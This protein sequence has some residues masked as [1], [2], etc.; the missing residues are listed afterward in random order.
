[1]QIAYDN[2]RLAKL[3]GIDDAQL[4]GDTLEALYK[5]GI[6]I[7]QD[8]GGIYLARV[9]D[10]TTVVSKSAAE[11]KSY[12]DKSK[13]AQKNSSTDRCHDTSATNVMTNVE[14]LSH[15]TT[16]NNLQSTNTITTTNT[17]RETDP[18]VEFSLSHIGE[19]E[20]LKD[21]ICDDIEFASSLDNSTLRIINNAYMQS[22]FLRVNYKHWSKVKINKDKIMT[23][24]YQQHK[25]P[26]K[27]NTTQAIQNSTP[28]R[29]MSH[30]EVNDLFDR[31]VAEI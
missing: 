29:A 4:V 3:I 11:R 20:Y 5:L 30:S 6:A 1:M 14:D 12:R 2:N 15:T 31:L 17:M 22:E 9:K 21:L 13:L 10:M 8:D 16:T 23:N 26:V 28:S 7:K 24:L 19:F 18:Q 27:Q 25:Y